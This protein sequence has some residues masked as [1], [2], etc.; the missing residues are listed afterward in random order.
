MKKIPV[1]IVG[2]GPTGLSLALALARQGVDSLVLEKNP[3]LTNHPKARGVHVRTMELFR[4]W[5]CEQA[6]CQ[7]ELPKEARRFIWGESLS[8]SEIARIEVEDE[9]FC[10]ESAAQAAIVSQDHVEASLYQALERFKGTTVAFSTECQ[11]FHQERDHVKV[12]YIH[13]EKGTVEEIEADYLIGADGVHSLVRQQLGIALEGPGELGSFC[14]V[15]CEMDL[16]PWLKHRPCIGFFFTQQELLRTS[17]FS[18][19]GHKRW[20]VG[21]RL[22]PQERP[23]DYTDEKCLHD[24]RLMTGSADIPLKLLSK[25]FWTMGA[26]NATSYREKRV[27]LVGDAAHKMPPAGGLGMNIGIQDAHNIAW[28]LAWVLNYGVKETL[29]DTYPQERAPVVQSAMEWS[30]QTAKRYF[31]IAAVMEAGNTEALKQ[32]IKEQHQS[33][34]HAGLDLGFIYHSTAI[35]SENDLTLSLSPSHYVPTTLPGA[36]APHVELNKDGNTLSTIDLFEK[37]CVLL[38]GK[39]GD[40]WKEASVHL[41]LPYP[42]TVYQIGQELLDPQ[43]VWHRAFEVETTGAVLVRPD[44]H[45]AWRSPRSAP[46]AK[47]VLQ[48]VFDRLFS[49]AH[50]LA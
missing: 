22:K 49:V 18:A 8:G 36:R 21:F 42:V 6:L 46:D 19:D 44:G 20:L 31:E 32:K 28:K 34:N 26:A 30:L 43:E 47:Q 3:T 17:L 10:Q 15:L 38:I 2:A 13:K 29:L 9:M 40:E 5:G 23:D 33:L 50:A 4:L 41:N 27:F 16:S 12:R 45:V 48:H 1:V 25:G 35:L 7:Y 24:I 37:H 14:S 39:K 11:S